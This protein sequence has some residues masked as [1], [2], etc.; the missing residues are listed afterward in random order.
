MTEDDVLR[1]LEPFE[2]NDGGSGDLRIVINDTPREGVDLLA[3]DRRL[4]SLRAHLQR[5]TS[6]RIRYLPIEFV[7]KEA[8]HH[9]PRFPTQPNQFFAGTQTL[10][11]L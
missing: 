5:H 11:A 3:G 7:W 4:L 1:T 9:P 10:L 2:A 6:P 8:M